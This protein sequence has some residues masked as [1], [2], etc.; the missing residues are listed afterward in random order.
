[1]IKQAGSVALSS[2]QAAVGVS[3]TVINA[4]VSSV[5]STLSSF[6]SYPEENNQEDQD[7]QNHQEIKLHHNDH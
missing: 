3:S 6:V 5:Y 7:N 4:V 1:V 2:G